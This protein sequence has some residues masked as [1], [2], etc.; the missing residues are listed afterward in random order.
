MKYHFQTCR[1]I[2]NRLYSAKYPYVCSK[3]VGNYIKGPRPE[4]GSESSCKWGRPF[5]CCLSTLCQNKPSHKAIHMKIGCA[6][7]FIFHANRTH[8][9]KKKFRA[10]TGF[11]FFWKRGKRELGNGLLCIWV[12]VRVFI[13]QRFSLLDKDEDGHLTEDDV[14][15]ISA[16]VVDEAFGQTPPGEVRSQ[17]EF[18]TQVLES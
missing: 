7:T 1:F 4:K 15:S 12:L 10:R 13:A 8:F 11:E 5:A 6:I 16:D 18:S 9:Q 14:M 2:F 3:F 17:I